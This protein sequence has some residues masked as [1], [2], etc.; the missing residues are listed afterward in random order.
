MHGEI[1][2]RRAA[3]GLMGLGTCCRQSSVQGET[4]PFGEKEKKKK[5]LEKPAG[6]SGVR[7]VVFGI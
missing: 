7:A 4:S 2:M 1:C 5:L 6:F 3:K